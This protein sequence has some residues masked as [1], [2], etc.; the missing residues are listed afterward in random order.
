MSHATI[1]KTRTYQE[2]L[3][4][5]KKQNKE[6]MG[7]VQVAETNVEEIISMV[8]NLHIGMVTELNMSAAVKSFDWWYDTR[9][10][11]HVCNNKDQFKHYEYV[12]ERQQVLMR[13]AN[14]TI[15]LGKENVEMQFISGKKLLLTNV[16]HAPEIC[17]NLVSAAILSKKGLKTVIE[18]NKL[19]VTKNDKLVER[20]TIV[21]EC[22][23]YVLL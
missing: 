18:T 19:I 5:Q 6:G 22:L 8:S 2:R 15:V 9:A 11:I 23:N 13:N 4:F 7:N 10:I 3:S 14:T 20:D 16:L 12:A 1:V 21:M 17:K